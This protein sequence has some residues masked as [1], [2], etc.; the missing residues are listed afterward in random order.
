MN[1]K[2]TKTLLLSLIVATTLAACN[3]FANKQSDTPT[4]SSTPTTS[5]SES[6]TTSSTSATSTATSSENQASKPVDTTTPFLN[7]S[8]ESNAQYKKTAAPEGI[9]M[10]ELNTAINTYYRDNFDASEK[11]ANLTPLPQ[12]ELQALQ[13]TLDQDE[14]LASLNAKVDQMSIQLDGKTNYVARIVVPMPRAQANQQVP[15]SEI[16]LLAHSLAQI[17]NRLVMIGYYDQ[18]TN[19]VIPVTLSNNSDPLF[20]NAE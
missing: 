5:S 4:E 12:S 11:E 7:E 2:T 15:E 16:Q 1:S 13:T 9:D 17:G 8:F 3:P 10:A 6:S 19:S 18:A 20:Y 14:N